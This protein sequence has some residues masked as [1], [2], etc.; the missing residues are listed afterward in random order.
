[1][2]AEIGVARNIFQPQPWRRRDRDLERS[3]LRGTRDPPAHRRKLGQASL[4][5]VNVE[6]ETVPAVSATP[7]APVGAWAL[8]ANVD[9]RMG[10]PDGTRLGVD[11]GER[12]ELAFAV[13]RGFSPQR[14]DCAEVLV[15]ARSPVRER[16]AE[17]CKLGLE[18]SSPNAKQKPSA[19]DD[20]DTLASSFARTRGFRWGRMMMPVAS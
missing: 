9:R 18:I 13:R 1:V 8:A 19:R 15:G 12:D 10:T 3:E 17:C 2:H 16:D 6:R 7:G 20:I 11:S 4:R 5:V 14:Q